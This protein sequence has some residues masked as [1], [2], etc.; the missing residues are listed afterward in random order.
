LKKGDGK[1]ISKNGDHYIGKFKDDKI[2]GDGIYKFHDG[3]M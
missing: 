3:K 2:D 1:Y